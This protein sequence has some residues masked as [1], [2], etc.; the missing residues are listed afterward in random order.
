MC[1]RYEAYISPD[2]E[3]KRIKERAEQL[4]LTYSEGEIFPSDEVLCFIPYESDVD[5]AS[6]KWGIKTKG[7][8]INA[9]IESINDKAMY[10]NMKNNRC[11][12][13]AN[14]FYEWDK[15]K[16]KYLIKT[17]DKYFYL[18]C[19]FNDANELL[20]IT[21]QAD[22]S[23]SHIHSRMPIIMNKNEMIEYIHNKDNRVSNKELIIKEVNE[24]L[25]LF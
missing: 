8:H 5:L 21:K 14:A 13:I 10:K 12:V 20:I 9:R 1:G 11:A 23:I 22:E 16:R 15:N 2:E 18:A 4:N 19:I 6:M 17:K 7:L 3:G 24:Q 25:S